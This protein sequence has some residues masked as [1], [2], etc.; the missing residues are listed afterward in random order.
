MHA[1]PRAYAHMQEHT[2]SWT[3]MHINCNTYT[4]MHT[5]TNVYNLQL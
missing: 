1:D 5:A 2:W 4:R 3:R